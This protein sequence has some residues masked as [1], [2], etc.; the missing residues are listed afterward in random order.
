VNSE[1]VEIA[2]AGDAPAIACHVLT[3]D[4]PSGGVALL[5]HGR[6]GIGLAGHM[7]PIAHA[8]LARG[9]RVVAPDLPY[10]AAKPQSGP[11][12]KIT[13]AIHNEN[14]RLAL[15]WATQT[16]ASDVERCGMALAGH[17]L[18]SHSIAVLAGDID[19]SN[20]ECHHLI[21]ISPVVSGSR[22][23][24]A[25]RA[26]GQPAVDALIREAPSMFE[27]MERHDSRPCLEKID[28]PLAV[29]TGSMDTLTP[30][31]A[32]R[33]YFDAAPGS[34]FFSV[35]EGLHHCPAGPIYERALNCALD[36]VG[37]RM[38]GSPVI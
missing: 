34:C 6:D 20:L 25:R 18:G 29:M 35:L 31:D 19:G 38:T 11:H 32:A 12:E 27:E 36:A 15:L 3:P 33:D 22:L 1:T 37:V 8:Y 17:S 14:A 4:D 21:A 13:L 9:W 5:I 2:G 28:A 16:F 10:S 30:P 23:L 26:M 7:L 24:A